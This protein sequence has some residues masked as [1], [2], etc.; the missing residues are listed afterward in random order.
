MHFEYMFCFICSKPCIQIISSRKKC[1]LFSSVFKK[2]I[3]T[4]TTPTFQEEGGHGV[5]Q[6]LIFGIRTS[7]KLFVAF[8]WVVTSTGP[9]RFM[10]VCD[11]N[12]RRLN[13]KWFYGEAETSHGIALTITKLIDFYS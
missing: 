10:V 13:R 5:T 12:S 7:Q 8:P 3:P 4:N 1:G 2:I 9:R 11:G 6:P